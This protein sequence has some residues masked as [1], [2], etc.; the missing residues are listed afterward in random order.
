MKRNIQFLILFLMTL[1]L[2]AC[3]P[4]PVPVSTTTTS[5]A[6][7]EPYDYGDDYGYGYDEYVEVPIEYGEPMYYAPPISVTFAF[8][9]FTYEID[10]GYVDIVF[11]KGGH[12]YYREP[13]HD[14]GRRMSA[15]D[16]R[17]SRPNYRVRGPEFYE[18]RRKL[19]KNHH[20]VHPDTYYKLERR[21]QKA[22]QKEQ[23]KRF[24][25][26]QERREQQEKMKQKEERQR[27]DQ[28]LREQK[29]RIKQ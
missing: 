17:S 10:N 8:D 24:R 20:I 16:I 18:H 15:H 3:V 2:S 23:D 25:Q 7:E 26:D 13:W 1:A 14:H 4:V 29:H 19:E 27:Q 9:Y 6:Y 12:R 11:W 21:K 28:E 22:I 5:S